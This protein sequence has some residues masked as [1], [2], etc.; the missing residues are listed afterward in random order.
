MLDRVYI[1]RHDVVHIRSAATA[2]SRPSS[3]QKST[4]RQHL[5]QPWA[6]PAVTSRDFGAAQPIVDDV[7]TVGEPHLFT[8][9]LKVGWLNVQ[10]L[11]NKT[12][13]V[14]ELIDDRRLDVLVLTETWHDSS[15]DI[16]LRL[17]APDDYASVDAVRPSDPHHGGV[18]FVHRKCYQCT[19][20]ALPRLSTFEGLCTRLS[21]GGESF[22]FLSIYR[23]GSVRPPTA[24][25][26]ELTSVLESLLL[27]SC[28]VLIGGD[29]NIHVENPDDDY[30]I[31]LAEVLTSFSFVQH[32]TGP[33][34]R[35]G[36]TLDLVAALADC[37][38]REVTV[39]RL[40]SSRIMA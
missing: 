19:Q 2:E 34:H 36:G 8:S 7:N 29:I 23:P 21:V 14:H 6:E 28:P 40:I 12:T 22:I 10:S 3:T 26:D 9:G 18:V 35:L 37:E 17:A 39:E 4:F 13:A 32:V 1:F 24:F 33:T 15:D 5:W 11:S 38:L 30:A 16:C 27:K 20:I 31:Q 25:F